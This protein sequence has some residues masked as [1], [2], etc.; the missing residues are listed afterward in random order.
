MKRAGVGLI[1]GLIA[2]GVITFVMH[3][4]KYREWSN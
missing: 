3:P 4:E 1:G 2:A